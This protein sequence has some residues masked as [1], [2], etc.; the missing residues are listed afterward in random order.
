MTLDFVC[1]FDEFSRYGTVSSSLTL[2]PPS[3][4]GLRLFEMDEHSME[5]IEFC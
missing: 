1:L 5:W 4:S 3:F 2:T